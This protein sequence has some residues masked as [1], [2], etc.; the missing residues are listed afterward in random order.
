MQNSA[1]R[2]SCRFSDRQQECLASLVGCIIP[3][4]PKYGLPG[5]DDPVILAEILTSVGRDFDDI[6]T[7]LDLIGEQAPEGLVALNDAERN[8]VIGAFRRDRPGVA[9]VIS[10]HVARCYYRNPR[11]MEAIGIEPRPPFPEGYR[12]STGDWN[13]LEPVRAR[14]KIFRDPDTEQVR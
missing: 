3:A 13:L 12:V 8:R 2:P 5:A 1:P 14:G 4:S 6:A 7:A 10:A 11:V 9:E